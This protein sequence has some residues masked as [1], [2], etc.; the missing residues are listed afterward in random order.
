MSTLVQRNPTLDKVSTQ[1]SFAGAGLLGPILNGLAGRFTIVLDTGEVFRSVKIY[2]DDYTY[3]P[4]HVIDTDTGNVFVDVVF[5]VD[6]D[7]GD[8]SVR[9]T[10]EWITTFGTSRAQFYVKDAPHVDGIYVDGQEAQRGGATLYVNKQ[11]PDDYR[12]KCVSFSINI[13]PAFS[14]EF[15]LQHE[16]VGNRY[17]NTI[18]NWGGAATAQ[19][20]LRGAEIIPETDIAEINGYYW[21]EPAYGKSTIVARLRAAEGSLNHV[22]IEGYVIVRQIPCP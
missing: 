16:Y 22:D 11:D 19:V 8:P 15:F 17:A 1:L 3:Y 12:E 4:S 9:N 5:G 6:T 7:R 18:R 20:F 2:S 10:I 13:L 21:L 14:D